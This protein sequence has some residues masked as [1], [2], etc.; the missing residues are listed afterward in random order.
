MQSRSYDVAA[1]F[2]YAMMNGTGN[3][4]NGEGIQKKLAVLCRCLRETFDLPE[5]AMLP[6]EQYLSAT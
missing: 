6:W 3:H 5:D 2:E 4:F 1:L